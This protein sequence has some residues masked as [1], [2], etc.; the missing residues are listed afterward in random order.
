MIGR[1]RGRYDLLDLRGHVA[2]EINWRQLATR[3]GVNERRIWRAIAAGG[4]SDE[5]AD[6]IAI[7]CGL[8]PANVWP[9]WF[10][11]AIEAAA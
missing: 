8:H 11:D 4:A 1:P 5:L 7:A 3:A 2:G 6:R 10:D 9:S